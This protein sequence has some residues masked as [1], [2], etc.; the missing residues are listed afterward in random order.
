MDPTE[1]APQRVSFRGC[2]YSAKFRARRFWAEPSDPHRVALDMS[3]TEVKIVIDH[4]VEIWFFFW[5]KTSDIFIKH[6]PA[7]WALCLQPPPLVVL[8]LSTESH[9]AAW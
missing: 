4:N 2:V 3:A 9:G 6:H 1:L 7:M 5:G 8:H